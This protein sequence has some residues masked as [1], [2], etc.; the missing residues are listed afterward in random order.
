[1]IPVEERKS[2]IE[3]DATTVSV[4]RQCSLLSVHRSGLYYKPCGESCENLAIMR[5]LDEQYLQTPFYGVERLKALL[6]R[7]GYRMNGKRLRRLMR[8]PVMPKKFIE[9]TIFII[10][11]AISSSYFHWKK[12]KNQLNSFNAELDEIEQ[13]EKE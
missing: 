11:L 3:R 9:L 6:L 8:I 1:M 4:S 5:I 2:M 10:L 13:L 7:K 12:F